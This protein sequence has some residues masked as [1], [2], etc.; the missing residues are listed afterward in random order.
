MDTP[1][2]E[3]AEATHRAD[4]V[5]RAIFFLVTHV[6]FPGLAELAQHTLV[7]RSHTHALRAK[8]WMRK[9]FLLEG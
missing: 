5:E 2:V 9:L 7:R 1:A 8:G 6:D 3:G 4:T